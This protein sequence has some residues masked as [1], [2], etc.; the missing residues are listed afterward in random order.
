MKLSAGAK[1]QGVSYRT[2]LRWFKAG[3]VPGRQMPSGTILVE[4]DPIL[5]PTHTHGLDT[6]RSVVVYARVSA[7]ENKSNLEAQTERVSAF[8]AANGWRITSVVKEV[9]SGV[10]D[11]RPKL[12][13]L[14]KNPGAATIVVEHKDRLTRFGF[15]Y[16]ETLLEQQG[17]SIVVIT[18]TGGEHE[19]IVQDF[20]AI[21]TSFCARLYGQRR[22]K[23]NTE[24][25]LASLEHSHATDGDA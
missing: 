20:V 17:R 6:P 2:A 8:C 1:Q 13:A 10:N 18:E 12:I 9:G 4:A 5:V 22:S 3:R 21:V 14:L 7:S 24:R 11:H 25:L 16:L 19:D 15:N 23:R